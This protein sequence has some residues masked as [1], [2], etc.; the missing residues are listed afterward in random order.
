MNVPFNFNNKH[1]ERLHNKNVTSWAY[2][3]RKIKII[4]LQH[5]RKRTEVFANRQFLTVKWGKNINSFLENKYF[6]DF[7]S[8]CYICFIGK[9]LDTVYVYII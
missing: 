9:D 7:V 2:N 8:M 3:T 6:I 5:V 4:K 1:N